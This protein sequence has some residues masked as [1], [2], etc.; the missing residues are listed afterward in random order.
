MRGNPWNSCPFGRLAFCSDNSPTILDFPL[1][2]VLETMVI[3]TL[4]LCF[5]GPKKM[6]QTAHVQWALNWISSH[7]NLFDCDGGVQFSKLLWKWRSVQILFVCWALNELIL[8]SILRRCFLIIVT[9]HKYMWHVWLIAGCSC[10]SWHSEENWHS[11]SV[12]WRVFCTNI[13]GR[14]YLG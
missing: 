2:S 3:N 10:F 9:R 5:P 13:A 8:L 1:H 12:Y 7:P 6:N 11:I 14:I 4:Y